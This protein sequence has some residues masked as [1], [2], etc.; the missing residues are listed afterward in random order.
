MKVLLIKDVHKLGHAGD[1]KRVANGYARNYLIPQGMAVLAT[2][3]ALKQVERIRTK[4][5]IR[6]QELNQEL[7]SLAEKIEGK[8]L[9]FSSRAGETGKLYGSITTQMIAEE[10][11]KMVGVEINRHSIDAQPIKTLG[12]HKA[13]INLTVDLTPE[14]TILVYREGEA[15]KDLAEEEAPEAEEVPEEQEAE[16]A[17]QEQETEEVAETEEETDVEETSES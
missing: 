11:S 4:A 2:P 5:N 10:L 13:E 8:V 6:R 3:G 17:P 1:V 7:S 16:E 9:K 15:P 12:E 14:I